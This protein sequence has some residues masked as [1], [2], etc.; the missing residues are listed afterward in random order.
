M[1]TMNPERSLVRIACLPIWPANASAT[2]TVSSAVS[3]ATTTS[4]SF[5]TGTGEKKCS[6]ITRSGRWVQ[7]AS[8]AIGIDEVLEARKRA[9][10][11]CRSRSANSLPLTRGSSVTA[12]HTASTPPS[13][14]RSVV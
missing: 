2:A 9:S 5:I 6:P 1:L 3:S 7:A 14:S 13:S 12:S 4:T 8:S 10:G 11:S